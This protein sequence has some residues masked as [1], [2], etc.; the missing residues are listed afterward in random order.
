[1]LR[2][3]HLNKLLKKKNSAVTCEGDTP[4]RFNKHDQVMDLFIL[5]RWIFKKIIICTESK[6]YNGR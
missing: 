5:I 4:V 3:L 6:I 1:M 2:K